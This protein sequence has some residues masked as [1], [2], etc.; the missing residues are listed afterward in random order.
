[1]LGHRLRLWP[2]ITASLGQRL[3][4]AGIARYETRRP[5][6]KGHAL[7]VAN[8]SYLPKYHHIHLYT[9]VSTERL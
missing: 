5:L 2:N 3:V 7:T 9:C 8:L 6:W 1:M 4:F